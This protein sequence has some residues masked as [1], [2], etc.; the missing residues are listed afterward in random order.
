MTTLFVLAVLVAVLLV[1]GLAIGLAAGLRGWVALAVAPLLTY[2]VVT[3]F[4]TIAPVVLGGWSALALVLATVLVAAVVGVV[5]LVT[6]RWAARETETRWPL[7][8]NL[9]VAAGI[10][11]AAGVG[12]WV[13]ARSTGNLTEVHQFWDAMFHA[14]AVRYIE[15]TGES[16]PTALRAINDSANASFRYPNAFHIVGATVLGITGAPITL[17]L[18]SMSALLAAQFA[19][20]TV[21]LVR[22]VGGR[23]VLAGAAAVCSGLFSA[24][25]YDLEFFGP[26]WP[27]ATGLALLPSAVVLVV[28][29]LKTRAPSVVIAAA[30][31][32][33]GMVGLHPSIAIAAV[34]YAVGYVVVR[35]I[36][37]RRIPLAELGALVAAGVLASINVVPQLLGMAATGGGGDYQRA[38]EADVPYAL[39]QLFFLGHQAPTPQWALVA[40]MAIGVFTLHRL[41]GLR[42]WLGGG[43]FFGVLFV[44]CSSYQG[45]FTQLVA[46]PWWNDRWRFVALVVPATAVLAGHGLTVARD[47]LLDHSPRAFAPWM[48]L[49]SVGLVVLALFVLSNGFFQGRNTLRLTK[50]Y[51]GGWPTVTA[52]EKQGIEELA[53]LTDDDDVVMNDAGDGS[54]WMYALEDIQ[55]VFGHVNSAQPTAE[56]VGADR[57]ALY[58]RFNR[59]DTDP[60]IR[61]IVQRMGI[62][63]VY[64]GTGFVAPTLERIPGL[65][66]LDDVKSLELEY[67]NDA[68]RIYKVRLDQT[69]VG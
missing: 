53:K 66:D 30:L 41:K 12:L 39:G 27:F 54:A 61:S 33:C 69:G 37:A 49:T 8:A 62:T 21:G 47:W 2:S 59:I 67:S 44:L 55:P 65:T 3:V 31:G 13:T 9:G 14:N 5:N 34:I 32:L 36:N 10:A 64:E 28:L 4:S 57:V 48:R 56:A 58:T 52:P 22:A 24:F 63:H 7:K 29:V 50:A 51:A 38:N 43:L 46:S 23:P 35:W 15:E 19:L 1:P 45:P 68:V 17:V 26:L 18:N 25:P 20:S 60:E 6:R 16:A 40:A 42:W 11:I